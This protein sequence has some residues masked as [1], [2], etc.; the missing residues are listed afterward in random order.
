MKNTLILDELW[1]SQNILDEIRE[2]DTIEVTG[3]SMERPHSG[4][5]S[6]PL[7]TQPTLTY[8]KTLKRAHTLTADGGQWDRMPRSN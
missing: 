3:E 7:G 6:A 2:F 5:L 1:V 8:R 4:G